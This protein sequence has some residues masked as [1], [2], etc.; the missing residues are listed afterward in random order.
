MTIALSLPV[1]AITIRPLVREDAEAFMLLRLAQAAESEVAMGCTLEEEVSRPME[2][3]YD[4]LSGG[5]E[6][7]TFGAFANDRLIGTA[8]VLRMGDIASYAHK[9]LLWGVIVSPNYRRRS[10]ARRLVETAIAHVRAQG[11]HRIQL[12][13]YEPN[14]AAR[15]LYESLGFTPYGV[16]PEALCLHG[17]YF[18]ACLMTLLV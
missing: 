11:A 14:E 4:N 5:P 7:Q 15:Q 2:R 17:A 8:A 6:A 1:T 10:V 18:D 3:F 16:E 12:C 13:M 9:Y